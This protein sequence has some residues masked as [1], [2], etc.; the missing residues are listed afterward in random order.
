M[1]LV[2]RTTVALVFVALALGGGGPELGTAGQNPGRLTGITQ[3]SYG[4]P[5]PQRVG[6]PCEHW[7]SFAHARFRLTTLRSGYTR[8]ITSD[9]R[10]R[11]SLP[12]T[13]GRYQLTPLRQLHTTGGTPITAT[14]HAA[15]TTW[16]HVRYQGFPQML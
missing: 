12:L 9:M 6:E 13:A 7:S 11:F 3:I 1:P 16:T 2:T 8:I 14:I 4:C 5:G 15:T 10:G